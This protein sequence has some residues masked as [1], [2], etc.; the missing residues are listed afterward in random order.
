MKSE[1]DKRIDAQIAELKAGL[2]LPDRER[3]PVVNGQVFSP[4]SVA[5]KR[6]TNPTGSKSFKGPNKG[7]V[8]DHRKKRST[9]D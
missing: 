3:W 5:P 8:A 1:R 7:Y 6:S 2:N 9:F 4:K